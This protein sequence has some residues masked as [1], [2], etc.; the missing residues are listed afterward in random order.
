MHTL[1][2]AERANLRAMATGISAIFQ[3]GKGGIGDNL[4]ADVSKAL[5][6]HELVKL[7][8]LKGAGVSAKEIIDD[9]AE[10]LDA[11]AVTAIGNKIVLY[12]R[13]KKDGIKHIK[14]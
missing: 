10:M 2:S 13:S 11:V 9:M 6:D 3:V 14:F 7:S 1:S 4:I 8:V 5:E 12:R